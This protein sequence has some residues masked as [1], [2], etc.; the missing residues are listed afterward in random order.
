LDIL[1]ST[2]VYRC[3]FNKRLKY[4]TVYAENTG[5]KLKQ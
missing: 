5:K 4:L 1:I 2:R 3:C